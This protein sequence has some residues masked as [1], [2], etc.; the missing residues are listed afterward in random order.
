MRE[1]VKQVMRY[2][3]PRMML[4]HP[5]LALQH[6]FDLLGDVPALGKKKH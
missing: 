5:L 2:A 3:G 4:K 6:L 1:R